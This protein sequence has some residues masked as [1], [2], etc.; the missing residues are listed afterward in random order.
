[1]LLIQFIT[2][3]KSELNFDINLLK[4]KVSSFKEY[5]QPNMIY[6]NY[7]NSTI[8]ADIVKETIPN[9]N[10]KKIHVTQNT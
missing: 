6:N 5:R 3:L 8:T 2:G 1:M 9:K 7:Y 10:Y 4:I